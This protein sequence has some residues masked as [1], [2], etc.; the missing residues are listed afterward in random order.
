M[1]D[2]F[3]RREVTLQT[4]DGTTVQRTEQGTVDSASDA[5]LTFSL[6]SG[7][8]VTVTIDD[9]TDAVAF[10]EQEVTSRRGLSRT[11]LAPAEVEIGD[12]EAGAEIVVWSDSED[13]AEFVA[14]RIVIQ[15]EPAA[16]DVEDMDAEEA[17]S[18]ESAAAPVVDA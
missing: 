2:D 11:R 10:S 14:Q 1:A 15:P 6:A 3:E 5:S 12:I 17:T 7:E 18:D 8:S 16:D 13:G 9:D 4:A